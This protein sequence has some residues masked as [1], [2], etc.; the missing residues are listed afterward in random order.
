TRTMFVCI[1]FG[2]VGAFTLLY[3][4]DPHVAALSVFMLGVGFAAAFPALLGIIGERY[5]ALSGT[6]FS[7]AIA[8]ALLGGTL[9]PWVA[10]LLGARY[11]M[12]GSF[13]LVPAA[14]VLLAILLLILTRALRTETS[15]QTIT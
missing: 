1:A 8:I 12:R 4:T 3:T 7:L 6:A 15:K 13:V 2:L 9:M 11:G 14:L 5:A 10:G